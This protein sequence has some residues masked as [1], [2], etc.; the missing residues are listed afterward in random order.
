MQFQTNRDS[1]HLK[2]YRVV[3]EH[4]FSIYYY[5]YYTIYLNTVKSTVVTKKTI[6]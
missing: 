4:K 2:I 3:D 1:K 5:Y 6:N